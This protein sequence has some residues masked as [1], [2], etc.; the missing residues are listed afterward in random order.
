MKKKIIRIIFKFKG[1]LNPMLNCSV[2]KFAKKCLW[3]RRETKIKFRLPKSIKNFF[4][5]FDIERMDN[6]K[7]YDWGKYAKLSIEMQCLPVPFNLD[8]NEKLFN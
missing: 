2:K 6:V 3:K 8:W 5:S 4:F 1:T 7:D